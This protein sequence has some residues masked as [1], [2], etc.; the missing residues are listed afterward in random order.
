MLNLNE[1]HIMF[2][3]LVA[4]VTSLFVKR[5]FPQRLMFLNFEHVKGKNGMGCRF[6]SESKSKNG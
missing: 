4:K 1:N 6:W 3:K 5:F 2:L